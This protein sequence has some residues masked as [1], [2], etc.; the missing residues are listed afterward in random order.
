[1]G[2][3][4]QNCS[5]AILI[6]I[7]PIVLIQSVTIRQTIHTQQFM[8]VIQKATCFR[9][10]VTAIIRLAVVMAIMTGSWWVYILNTGHVFIIQWVE[11]AVV[12]SEVRL[13]I[14]VWPKM[15]HSL[16]CECHIILFISSYIECKISVSVTLLNIWQTT[17][18]PLL[19]I[20]TTHIWP[21]SHKYGTF[22][23]DCLK[24]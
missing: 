18:L 21:P 8:I 9:L 22:T 13:L 12:H 2:T 7:I 11:L 19:H 17:G 3:N 1:M 6:C 15:I 5:T 16:Y 24:F 10:H 4:V 20:L 14:Y 23:M